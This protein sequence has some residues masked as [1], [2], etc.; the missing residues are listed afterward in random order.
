MLSSERKKFLKNVDIEDAKSNMSLEV[1]N[2][3]E[4]WIEFTVYSRIAN[5]FKLHSSYNFPWIRN[6]PV[7][8]KIVI[9]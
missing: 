9:T 2:I 6:R 7:D 4:D 8:T 5:S 1:S 3:S